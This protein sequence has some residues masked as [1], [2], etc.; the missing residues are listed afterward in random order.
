[1]VHFHAIVGIFMSFYECSASH[2]GSLCLFLKLLHDIFAVLPHIMIVCLI[3]LF[4][5][6]I[7]GF[8]SHF[9]VIFNCC[10]IFFASHF[11]YF[12]VFVAGEEPENLNI[13]LLVWPHSH[14]SPCGSRAPQTC[15]VSWSTSS[16]SSAQRGPA[17]RTTVPGETLPCPVRSACPTA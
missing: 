16:P 7:L 11:G 3:L 13:V 5:A 14:A 8:L 12:A 6:L 10:R 17:D 4:I 9:V 2:F 15:T 1:M